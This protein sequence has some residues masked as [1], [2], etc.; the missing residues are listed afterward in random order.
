MELLNEA[1]EF[2]R[3]QCDLSRT[4]LQV[5]NEEFIYNFY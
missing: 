3:V 4:V 2:L 1:Y 5:I